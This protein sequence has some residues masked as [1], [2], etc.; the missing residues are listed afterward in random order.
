MRDTPD[1]E[2]ITQGSDYNYSGK[3]FTNIRPD[4]VGALINI[5]TADSYWYFNHGYTAD[6][7]L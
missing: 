3:S 5:T 1:C 2:F 6:A 7:E 4:H